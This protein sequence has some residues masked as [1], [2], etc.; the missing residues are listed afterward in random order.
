MPSRPRSKAVQ[1]VPARATT[2]DAY[3]E[4]L[5]HPHKAAIQELRAFL[6]SLDPRIQEEV[7]WNA[8]SFYL[9]DNF[10]TLRI[11]PAPI[12]QLVLHAGSKKQTRPKS[13][14]VEDPHGLLTWPAQDRCVVT[15]ARPSDVG[16][17]LA[18]LKPI[19][20]DWIRQL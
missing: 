1:A 9:T 6:L 10:A 3:M 18:Y 15:F 17:N 4:Q 7:K 19:V 20:L 12:L 8:P 5:A 2:V 13:F 16:A 11:H 14:Q